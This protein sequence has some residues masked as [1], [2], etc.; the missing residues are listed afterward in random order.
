MC[1]DSSNCNDFNYILSVCKQGPIVKQF[2]N[3]VNGLPWVNK[4]K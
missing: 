2:F 3:E 4:F 1:N